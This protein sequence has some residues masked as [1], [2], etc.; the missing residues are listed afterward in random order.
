MQWKESSQALEG[1][2]GTSH[3][4]RRFPVPSRAVSSPGVL[5]RQGASP[6]FHRGQAPRTRAPKDSRTSHNGDPVTPS[7]PTLLCTWLPAAQRQLDLGTPLAPFSGR[8][9]SLTI[10]HSALVVKTG[11]P[12]QASPLHSFSHLTPGLR[13]TYPAQLSCPSIKNPLIQKVT[14]TFS[15][16]RNAQ[17]QGDF[18]SS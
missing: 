15:I 9:G 17:V 12:P 10:N 13:T 7:G 6:S 3:L 1:R 14:L 16:S 5:C 18:C 8:K 11:D 2:G 4:W